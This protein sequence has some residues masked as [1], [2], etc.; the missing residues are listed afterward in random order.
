MFLALESGSGEA[1]QR[2]GI[3][4]C[5]S[6]FR[7]PFGTQLS[8]V[9]GFLLKMPSTWNDASLVAF[10]QPDSVF[11]TNMKDF[12]MAISQDR[13]RLA[14]MHHRCNTATPW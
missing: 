6:W 4:V 1:K 8:S 9:E 5:L 14:M 7:W 2:H 10:G 12:D 3:F 11:F 13:H